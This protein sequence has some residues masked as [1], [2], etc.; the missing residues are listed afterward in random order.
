MGF[1]YLISEM[2]FLLIVRLPLL[3]TICLS[4]VIFALRSGAPAHVCGS[5]TPRHSGIEPNKS[6]PPYQILAAAGE[7]RIRVT[8][9]SPQ[10]SA[11][12]GFIINARSVDTGEYV[13]EFTN[14]PSNVKAIECTPGL[15][16]SFF[17]LVKN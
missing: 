15:K 9:G 12:Q 13:G 2:M 1:G 3:L 8:L 16:V 11:F 17:W 14:L 7:G 4:P 10:G 6:Y 5:M